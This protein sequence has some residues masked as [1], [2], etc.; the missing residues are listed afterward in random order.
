MVANCHVIKK[1][2]NIDTGLDKTYSCNKSTYLVVTKFPDGAPAL[3]KKLFAKL[4][5]VVRQNKFLGH[6]H[7]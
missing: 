7:I 3:A 2:S 4:F 5:D 6:F 1:S